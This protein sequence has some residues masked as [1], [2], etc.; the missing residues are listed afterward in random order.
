MA[1]RS[2]AAP[3]PLLFVNLHYY[4]DVASTGQHLTDL[5]EHLAEKGWRVEVLSGCGRYTAGR[6]GL[7]G[8]EERNGVRIRRLL[9]TTFG[10]G[11]FFGRLLDYASF[12][13]RAV[14]LL[15]FGPRY[16]GVVYLTT[17]PLLAFLGRLARLLRGQRYAVWSM[18]LHPDAEFAAGL[19]RAQSLVGRVLAWANA[20][21]MRHADFV[22]DLGA[23]MKRR[24]V[25][26]GVP[27][28]RTHT[29][30]VWSSSD[31]VEP[32]PIAENPLRAEL[33]LRDKFVVM[34]SGNAGLVH[35]FRDILVA[36]RLLRDES[37]IHF[38]FVGDGPR[39]DAIEAFAAEHDLRNFEYRDY[40]PREH[41]RWSLTLADAHLISLR[42]AFVGISVPGK[43]YGIMASGRP[44]LFVGPRQC[45]SADTIRENECG[46]VFDP[47]EPG[48]GAALAQTIREWSRD[49]TPAELLGRNGRQAFVRRFERAISCEAFEGVLRANWGASARRAIAKPIPAEAAA[50]SD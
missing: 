2:G 25:Q 45:E 8:R 21:A 6:L 48:A 31:E 3:Q 17:P 49:R 7:P 50:V 12:Y 30:H 36:M 29:V 14:L 10:R 46:L 20:S 15:L 34:Y 24:I 27:E 5:A 1:D 44:A 13:I 32:L 33:G 41:L 22:V 28:A 4:P 39:R 35:D 37:G 11:T 19:I 18:D 23:Y 47:A 40:F 9:G 26:M 16:G 43:L 42:A 38:L